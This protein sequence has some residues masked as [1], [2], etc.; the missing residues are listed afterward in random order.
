MFTLKNGLIALAVGLTLAAAIAV[1]SLAGAGPRSGLVASSTNPIAAGV[2]GLKQQALAA[3]KLR[4]VAAL[5]RRKAHFDTVLARVS[6]RLVRVGTLADKV[7]AAGGD[8]GAVKA[9]LAGAQAHL[10]SARGLEQQAVTAF[11]AV[12]SAA[13]KR[14][15]FQQAR[16][17]GR[18]AGTELRSARGQL[19]LAVR[20]LRLVAKG[21]KQASSSGA[22][23]ANVQ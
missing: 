5:E 16:G 13:N 14:V 11:Q 21:L 9:D 4:V 7:A 12:P 8:V 2:A 19:L 6:T 15:A 1:P 17:V 3:L 23:G 20:E 22:A 18:Q 10:D